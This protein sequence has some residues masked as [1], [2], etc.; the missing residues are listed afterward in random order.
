MELFDDISHSEFRA[1][2]VALRHELGH[3]LVWFQHGE[4]IGPIGFERNFEGKL[5]KAHA[6]LWPR[7][8]NRQWMESSS[9]AER[10]AERWLAGEAA[11]RR[12]LNL[13][14]DQIGTEY[15][16]IDADSDIPRVLH[17]M[18]EDEDVARVLYLAHRT[19][20]PGWYTWIKERLARVADVLDGNWPAIEELAKRLERDL[21]K[22][23]EKTRIH[24]TDLIAYLKKKRV[25][26]LTEPAVEIVYQQDVGDWWIRLKRFYR[27][28]PGDKATT[29]LYV[30]A[31]K[32]TAP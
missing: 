6:V 27:S 28:L 22:R 20:G 32:V 3:V 23:G 26:S 10:L 25:R 31:P 9:Y 8:G 19:T 29:C 24:G 4:A 5:V 11:A 14:T 12:A 30:N 7:D 17:Q 2:K 13:R 18:S 1:G 16:P 15:V 21:P